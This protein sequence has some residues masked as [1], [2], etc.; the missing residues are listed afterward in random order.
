MTNEQDLLDA[1]AE[2]E[3][4]L[5]T[6]YVKD[7]I[8]GAAAANVQK[9]SEQATDVAPESKLDCAGWVAAGNSRED[10]SQ[11]FGEQRVRDQGD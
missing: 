6:H 3:A 7:K 8:D 2:L 1:V 4:E 5:T 9:A 11:P 10:P